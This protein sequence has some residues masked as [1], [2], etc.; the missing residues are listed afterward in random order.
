MLPVDDPKVMSELLAAFEAYERVLVQNDIE[1]ING[2][3]WND[4]R[5]VRFGTRDIERQYGHA[6]IADFR[7]R[8][9]AINQQRGLANQRITTFGTDFGVT[10]MEFRPVGSDKIGRQTQT[11]IRTPQGWKIA[12]AHVS[13]GVT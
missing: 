4:P 5:T 9:G 12:S 2:L 3:F 1:T 11:W 7:I 10:T 8:R 13:F 6:A